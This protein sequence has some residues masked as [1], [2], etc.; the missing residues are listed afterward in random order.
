VTQTRTGQRRWSRGTHPSSAK[1][2]GL[3]DNR[4]GV[5]TEGRALERPSPSHVDCGLLLTLPTASSAQAR[6]A[7]PSSSR[8]AGSGTGAVAGLHERTPSVGRRS[9]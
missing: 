8:D 6:K 7:V 4:I 5:H 3:F 2:V 9:S 1:F